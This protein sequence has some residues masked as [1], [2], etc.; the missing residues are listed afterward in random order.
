VDALSHF[1]AVYCVDTEFHAPDGERPRGICLCGRELRSGRTLQR[2][3]WDDPCCAPLLP[4]D[5]DTL[6]VSYYASAEM[7]VFLALNWPMP[8]RIIDLH[9][10]FR[11][12]NSGRPRPPGGY[13]LLGALAAF[14]LPCMGVAA[15][16]GMQDV[17]KRGGPFSAREHDA[18]LAYC[19]EDAD[20]VALLLPAMRPFLDIPRA[21]LRGRYAPAQARIERIAVPLD[22]EALAELRE[23][24]GAVQM[25]LIERVDKNYGVFPDGHFSH[26]AFERYTTQHDIPWPRLPSGQL[27]LTEEVFGEMA[28][29]HQQL[30][31]LHDLRVSLAQ[32]HNWK[33]QVGSD[34]RNRVMLSPFASKTG[35]NQPSNAKFIFG[36]AIW[37]RG[38]IKPAEGTALAYVDWSGQEYGIAAAL[39]GD[40]AMQRDYQHGD[41][42]IRF[43]VRAGVLPP[44][45]T[46]KT[47]ARERELFKVC[48]G[49]AAM[50][51]M[52]AESLARRIRRPVAHARELL[53]LH[54]RS[55][56]TFWRWLDAVQDFAML[57]G[58]LET[59]F[60]WRVHVGPA[61]T[62]GSLRNFPMQANGA[63]MLRLACCLATERGIRVCGP[64]H[65]ALL[66]QGPADGIDAVVTATREAMREAS[67]LVLPGFSLRTEARVVRWPD[68]YTDERGEAMWDTVWGII[69]EQTLNE[70]PVAPALA[71]PLAS[72]LA[73]G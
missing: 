43:A 14:G 67:E 36:P 33:L 39:S 12:L 55:Y 19:Q 42:Y 2:W 72:A 4:V 54:H 23:R 35:R 22:L 57:R 38:L 28:L 40:E 48:C 11:W 73:S 5:E 60:G 50:Y 61:T 32:L 34:G 30:K 1:H 59:V 62:R 37:L 16:E 51:G 21:L 66:V 15:K 58:Y 6:F 53:E 31:P 65:D 41:P 46:K 13:G 49:I 69:R 8:R 10:E 25:R 9:A 20:A 27:E 52:G 47:H 56:P 29:A 17:A 71:P 44:D 3:L 64:V 45:A 7:G 68:R 26:A 24:W 70:K 63:E 18:L